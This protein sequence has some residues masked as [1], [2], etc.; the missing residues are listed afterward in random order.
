MYFLY[1]FLF[2]PVFLLFAIFGAYRLWLLLLYKNSEK[3]KLPQKEIKEFPFV[4]IQIPI[5]NEFNVVER[6]VESAVKIDYPRE[7]FEIQIL[8]DSTDETKE[9]VDR[10][11]EIKRKEGFNIY[12][13]RRDNR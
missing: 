3:V 2:F 12:V 6:I 13:I 4:T 9:L 7:K 10:L 1:L 11:V 5:Y 8:D